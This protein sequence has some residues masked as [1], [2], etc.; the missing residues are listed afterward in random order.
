GDRS[1]LEQLFLNLFI[2]AADA[3]GGEGE[4][5]I[6]TEEL[7]RQPGDSADV[8]FH[9]EKICLLTS[10]KTVKVTIA[11]T[12]KGIDKS[13]LPHIFEPFFTTKDPGQGTGLGLSIAYGIIQMH[14]GFIDVESEPGV[15]TTFVILLPA[16]VGA[17]I[18]DDNKNKETL[19]IG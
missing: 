13:Y 8:V 16:Y 4:L 9:D 15:G 17:G 12:G 18:P 3:M 1:R 5:T 11:D 19:G 14:S 7:S 2:N 6:T 10:P